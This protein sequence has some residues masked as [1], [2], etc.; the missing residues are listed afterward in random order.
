M[1][2]IGEKKNDVM[3]LDDFCAKRNFVDTYAEISEDMLVSTLLY[4][5]FEAER[6]PPEILKLSD[7]YELWT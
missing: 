5:K 1:E 3:N 6:G 4:C 2:K 7:F